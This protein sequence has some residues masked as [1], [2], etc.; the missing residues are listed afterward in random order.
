MCVTLALCL[1]TGPDPDC[2]RAQRPLKVCL[3]TYSQKEVS[4]QFFIFSFLIKIKNS[5]FLFFFFV[6]L[7][8]LFV[9][10]VFYFFLNCVF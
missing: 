10:F 5:F 3:R 9:F 2:A 7:F 1:P 6:F 8:V 4:Y